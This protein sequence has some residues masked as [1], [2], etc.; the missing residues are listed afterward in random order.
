MRV[1]AL[2]GSRYKISLFVVDAAVLLLAI[3]QVDEAGLFP[4]SSVFMLV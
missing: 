3:T 2:P 1:V 4:V